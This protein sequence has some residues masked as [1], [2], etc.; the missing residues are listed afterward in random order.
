MQALLDSC[1][2]NSKYLKESE[3][4]IE[5]IATDYLNTLGTII[6]DEAISLD[7]NQK[8]GTKYIF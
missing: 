4:A 2:G 5:F 7:Q 3:K 8:L 6:A 1:T